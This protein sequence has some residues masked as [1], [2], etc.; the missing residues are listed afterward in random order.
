M[1]DGL[2]RIVNEERRTVVFSAV[3]LDDR[4]QSA[5]VNRTFIARF[6]SL[7]IKFMA[8]GSKL[9][10]HRSQKCTNLSSVYNLIILNSIKTGLFADLHLNTS[11]ISV[12]SPL[13][14]LFGEQISV[15]KKFGQ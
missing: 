5:F 12:I 13:P 14:I 2:S 15:E 9:M 4:N 3:C 7:H 1:L 6:W 11:Q 10:R 8:V